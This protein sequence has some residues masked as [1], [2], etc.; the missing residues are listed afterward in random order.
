[1]SSGDGA[2][3][4]VF[5]SPEGAPL[6]HSNFYRRAWMPAL[7]VVCLP[8]VH[9]RDLRQTGNQFAA[10]SGANIRELMDRMGHDSTQ[11]R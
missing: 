7:T 1:M 11:P 8:G 10:D 4:L 6:R 5:T 2:A 3:A 9:F